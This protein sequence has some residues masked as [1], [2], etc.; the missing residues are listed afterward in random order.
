MESEGCVTVYGVWGYDVRVDKGRRENKG[1]WRL[2]VYMRWSLQ[3][4]LTIC[5]VELDDI[6]TNERHGDELI[7]DALRAFLNV[8]T[9]YRSMYATKQPV[10]FATVPRLALPL[11]R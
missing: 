6:L 8:T 2:G 9:S 11:Q 5:V 4:R 7:D 1:D 3:R 10:D